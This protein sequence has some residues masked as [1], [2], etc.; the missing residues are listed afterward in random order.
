[1][2]LVL[3]V[4]IVFL[5]ISAGLKLRRGTFFRWDGKNNA[6]GPSSDADDSDDRS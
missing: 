1:M 6:V 4:L 5:V 3:I 2:S